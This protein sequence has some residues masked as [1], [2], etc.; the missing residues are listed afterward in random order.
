MDLL[1]ARKNSTRMRTV[2]LLTVVGGVQWCVYVC[3]CPEVGLSRDVSWGVTSWCVSWVCVC[4]CVCPEV[5]SMG[6]V[7]RGCTRPLPPCEQ[8][9]RQV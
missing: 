9:D 6:D 2:R 5:L 4:V 7:T 1:S 8:N 3:V